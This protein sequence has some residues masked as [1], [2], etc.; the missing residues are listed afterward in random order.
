MSTSPVLPL[1]ADGTLPPVP[2]L[3]RWLAR[4][5]ARNV[6]GVRMEGLPAGNGALPDLL[7]SAG[8]QVLMLGHHPLARPFRWEGWCGGHVLVGSADPAAVRDLH[9]GEVACAA[10]AGD[11][12]LRLAGALDAARLEDAKA[13]STGDGG[14][15]AAWEQLLDGFAADQDAG[16]A[17]RITDPTPSATTPDVR[18]GAWNPLAFARRTL[19]SLPVPAG[20]MPR[21][22]RDQRGVRHPVQVVEGARGRELLTSVQLG[23]L[24]AVTF[25]PLDT[26]VSGS[27]WEVGDT[28]IDNGRVR[29]E[30][31]ALGQ[32]AR[33]CCDG[34]FVDWSGPALQPVVDDLPLG[35]TVGITVLEN[36][37]IRGRIG[38]TRVSDRGTL[39]LVYTLHAHE[40]VLR[41]SAAWD[42]R[43]GLRLAC[44]TMAHAAPLEIAGELSAWHLPQHAVAGRTAMAPVAGV[45]WARLSQPDRAGLAMLG[46]QPMTVSASAGTLS[47]HL[48][49]AAEVALCE[50]AWPTEAPGIAQQTL[51]L[52]VPAQA[53]T[54][55]AAPLLRL[56]GD[57]V[58][59]WIA[60]PAGWR[61]ELL[62]GQPHAPRGRCTLYAS[63][64]EAVRVDPRGGITPLRRTPEGDGFEVELAAGEVTTVRWR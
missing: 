34:R 51:A 63:A 58:P 33:L 29:V 60:R 55:A 39:R 53:V 52:A 16:P 5:A 48:T 22:L 11:L 25:A 54:T 64:G 46:L 44:P 36:G 17:R 35:G 49:T 23:A 45:R 12:D 28:V 57:A 2:F 1:M 38:V 27:H 21:G 19:V 42:G 6:H 26:P 59:W 56:V 4:M 50:S 61:G 30:L 40:T 10:R 47:L 13:V 24:E 8:I 18:L 14:L 31:D 37:P 41:L 9:L 62:L 7:T 15:G 32:V 43:A 20:D 3:L